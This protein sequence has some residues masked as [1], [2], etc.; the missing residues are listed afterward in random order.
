MSNRYHELFEAEKELLDSTTYVL[1][2][3][4]LI[5]AMQKGATQ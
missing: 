5:T 1:V 2:E 3:V 4:D